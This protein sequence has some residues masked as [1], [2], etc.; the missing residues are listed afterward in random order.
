MAV[1]FESEAGALSP[2]IRIGD[3]FWVY[4]VHDMVPVP[5]KAFISRIPIKVIRLTDGNGG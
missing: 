1:A 3:A 5:A 2:I 4:A